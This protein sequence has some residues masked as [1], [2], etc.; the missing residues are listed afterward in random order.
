MGLERISAVLQG[1]HDN[2]EIDLFK[3]LIQ[4]SSVETKT[5]INE[6]TITPHKVIADHIRSS[7][8]LIA[9]GVFLVTKEEVMF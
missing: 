4:A 7:A 6:K 1:T 9:E 3:K 2:Y 8:F 5:Q